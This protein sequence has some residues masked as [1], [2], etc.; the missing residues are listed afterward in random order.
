MRDN[1]SSNKALSWTLGVLVLAIA[2][3]MPV[4]ARISVSGLGGDIEIEGFLSSEARANVGSGRTYL[5]QW[6]QRLQIE[7]NLGYTDVGMFDE[8]SFTAIVRP[9]FDVAYYN[10]LGGGIT[11]EGGA[12]SYYSTG[13]FNH[14]N[15]SNPQQTTATQKSCRIYESFRAQVF[16]QLFFNCLKTA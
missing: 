9:E 12:N 7:V 16:K 4:Q 15:D 13:N 5:T 2:I 8:L 1:P 10:G 14:F 3:A 6:I 11:R